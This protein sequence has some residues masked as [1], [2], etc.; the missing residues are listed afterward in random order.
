MAKLDRL[1]KIIKTTIVVVLLIKL[2]F[3][4]GFAAPNIVA[5][6]YTNEDRDFAF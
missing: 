4:A 5:L 6:F 2:I 1:N 3:I